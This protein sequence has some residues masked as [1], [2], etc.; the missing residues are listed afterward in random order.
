[1]P[2]RPTG[3]LPSAISV[4]VTNSSLR[5]WAAPCP[6][7]TVSCRFSGHKPSP[8][9]QCAHRKLPALQSLQ[10]R[11]KRPSRGLHLGVQFLGW[12]QL[13]C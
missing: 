7:T 9:H 4:L 2:G 11:V 8:G 10:A 5:S 1:M 13:I 12:P 6:K 3:E